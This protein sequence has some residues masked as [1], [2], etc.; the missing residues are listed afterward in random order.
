[1][2]ERTVLVSLL[3]TPYYSI[4]SPMVIVVKNKIQDNNVGEGTLALGILL[5]ERT[6]IF[7]QNMVTE[8]ETENDR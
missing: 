7:L 6:T 3:S 4:E 8:K 5:I 2:T 1:M